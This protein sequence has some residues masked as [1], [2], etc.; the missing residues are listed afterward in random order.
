VVI[1][2]KGGDLTDWIQSHPI[3]IPKYLCDRNS[4][5]MIKYQLQNCQILGSHNLDNLSVA[6]QVL[7]LLDAPIEAFE[8]LKLF[9]GLSHRVENL[10]IHK[11]IRYV[12]DSKATTIESVVTAVHSTIESVPQSHNLWL[13]L[14]GK[15]KN[16]PWQDLKTLIQY[17]NLKFIFFGE[18]AEKAKNLSQLEG[19]TFSQL[20]SAVEFAKQSAQTQDTVLLSPGGTS[21]DEFKNFEDRGNHYKGFC[22]L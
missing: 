22:F 6:A 4:P 21:L 19:P 3:N 20:K 18:C 14:G 17:P 9:A 5:L 15:D 12:N 16:L 7:E 8:R 1:N 10:G 2:Q 13:L 11:G